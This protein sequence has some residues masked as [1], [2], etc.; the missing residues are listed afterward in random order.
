MRVMADVPLMDD[1]GGTA[2]DEPQPRPTRR[3][4]DLAGL[5]PAQYEA[6]TL[7]PGPV[8]V[9]A[10]AGSGKTRVLTH[11][12]AYLI[13]ELGVSPFEILA[14]TFT[15]KAA[16]EMRERVAELVG[17]VAKRMWVSTFHSACSRILR[18]E[19]TL[20][21]YRS[22]FSI[23]D[24]A[25]AQRLT[26]WIR[27]DQNLDP[28]R[29][30]ARQIHAQI[31]ALKN[32]L[33]LPAEYAQLAVGPAE[34]RL[35]DIYTEY[36]RRLQEAS[37]VDFDDL[38]VLAVRLF[39]EHPE[40]LERYRRRFQHVLVDE[41]QDT[42]AAQ[43]EL[44]RLL[45]SAHRSV[46]VVGDLDQCL[47]AGTQVTMADRTTK[48]IEDV[49]VGDIVLS[50]HGR[51]EFR[52]VPVQRVHRSRTFAAVSIT[53]ASG[54]NLVS[55]PEHVHFAGY[56][57]GRG[58]GQHLTY[59]M[60]NPQAGF[61][62]GPT[63]D[64][65]DDAWVIGTDAT[66]PAAHR[67]W[68]AITQWYYLSPNLRAD[69]RD[70]A[71]YALLADADLSFDDPHHV[72]DR[73]TDP[74]SMPRPRRLSVLCYADCRGAIPLHRISVSGDDD[75]GRHT[76]ERIGFQLRSAGN[77]S[78]GWR[79]ETATTDMAVIASTV[80]RIR[81]VLD[82]QVRYR[83]NLG[84]N[85]GEVSAP[86][87]P[88]MPASSI[89]AGMVMVDETGEF[90]VVTDVSWLNIDEPVFDLDVHRTHNFVANGL[91]THNSIY[92]FR[93]ADFRNLLKFEEQFP[94]AVTV[95]LDQNYRSSQR[96]LDAA[97]AVI[98][99][100]PSHRPKHLWTDKGEG[101]PIVRYQGDD[102]HDEA[103]FVVGEIHRLVD[104]ADHRYGDIAVFYRTN[105]QS[106][107]V[108]ESLVRSGVPYR[109]FGGVKFY[110][111]REIKDALAYLRALVNPD[112]EVSWKRI[113]NTPRRGVGDTSVAKIGAYASGANIPFPAAIESA[114]AAGVTGKALGGLRDLLELMAEAREAATR[115][116][117]AALETVLSRSGYLAELESE[118]SIEAQG[119]IENLQELVGSTREFDEQVERGDVSGLV[120]IGG[121]GVGASDDEVASPPEGLARV[122]SFLEAI[123][124][125]TDLDDNDPEQSTVTLMTLHSAKG[126]EY[127]VVFL[128][129]LEDGVFP[130]VRSLGDP[131]ELEEER[132]LCYVGITRAEQR[133]YLCH[134]WSRMMFGSTDYRPPSRFLDE[135]PAELMMAVGDEPR[136]GKGFG[137]HRDAVV[138]AAIRRQSSPVGE[139]PLT[140]SPPG[141]HGAD[142][143]GLHVG[144]DVTHERFGE[145]VILD[146]E[147]SGDKAEAIVRFRDAGEKRLLLVWAPLAR[148]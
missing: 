114:A 134:A 115:G 103:A 67:R 111:R 97:N 76:L 42:N 68:V 81:G 141:G 126:L 75:E 37:A 130:H 2:L 10:G 66:E 88:F 7:P 25:D 29:F 139:R 51:G 85:R 93:G 69:D 125:V 62:V 102:E 70:K 128:I 3:E 33:V 20:L 132:R 11:R 38:L 22:S 112:D 47:V 58:P 46:M 45:S 71:G 73:P 28:K 120:A 89:R 133:L 43:W 59:L 54:R 109:V 44:V 121:V 84:S 96:I 36:Q 101:E 50:C 106:R 17:P 113:V 107:V 63:R 86:S 13:G 129:G 61:R 87:L 1:V 55:T 16:G 49:S 60:W 79:Y 147:G 82:V 105:A 39:R 145:G 116:V 80:E 117:A 18:R 48:A 100:N 138:A 118:R 140:G 41:F 124:L 90:D 123:S 26:D 4:L 53:F 34:R 19:A 143:I 15:N 78:R 110:D 131:D 56:V 146:I 98:E 40:A 119:R 142:Q 104:G 12:L 83:A 23:Y 127:P 32:E 57:G 8:L 122:Q 72:A 137:R 65:H 95:V 135:I 77:G 35:S 27:R 94:E 14:I 108:E 24:E 30:P 52:G 5:N 92:K 148:V 136:R 31:S 64:R 21:G 6:V 91:V 74:A 9:V 99:N 144:D